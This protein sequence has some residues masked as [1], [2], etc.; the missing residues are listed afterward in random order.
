MFSEQTTHP[1]V[2]INLNIDNRCRFLVTQNACNLLT[3][4]GGESEWKEP[5]NAVGAGV[6]VA[7]AVVVVVAVGAGVVVAVAVVV[8]VVVAAGVVVVVGAGVAVAVGAGFVVAVGPGVRV[9]VGPGLRVAVEAGVRVAVGPGLR[10]AFGPGVRIVVGVGLGL[11]R[12]SGRFGY[13]GL[14]NNAVIRR[15][16]GHLHVLQTYNTS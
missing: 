10:D 5:L 14:Q 7:V 8:V 6:V 3:L 2:L 1:G 9:T 4:T 16:S 15:E 11:P 13:G 12:W